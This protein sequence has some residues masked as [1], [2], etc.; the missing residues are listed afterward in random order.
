MEPITKLPL[1][2]ILT[3]SQL[4]RKIKDLLE[5]NFPEVWVEG[6][7]S[8][9][10]IPGS[11]HLYFTLKDD[12]CQ[13]RAV[14]FRMQARSLRYLPEDGLQVVCRG[15][16]GLYEKRGDYQLI[17]DSM[18]PK[19][20]GAL[21]LAFLQ[22]KD[23][24]E[25]EGLFA[26]ER[27]KAVP[28]VPGKIGIVTSPTG[29]A[30]RDM[31]H[32]IHRRFE[33]VR[34]LLYPARV[35]GNGAWREIVEGI[36]FFNQERNVDVILIGRGGG[37]LEDLWAFNEEGLARAI[38]RSKIPIVS[39]VGHET[40]YTIS[41]FVADLR[42]PTPS[43]AAEQVVRDKKEVLN[44]LRSL[45]G[46]M[47]GE[48]A[49]TFQLFRS[50]LLHLQ[51][52][53]GSPQKALG[54]LMLRVDDLVERLERRS[55]LALEQR[56]ER[57]R[58]LIRRLQQT[59]PSG[60]IMTTR[61]LISET[62]KHLDHLIGHGIEIKEQKIRGVIGKLNALSPLSILERGYSIVRKLPA[63][64][65]LR[66]SRQVDPGDEVEIRLHRGVIL[67]EVKKTGLTE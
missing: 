15:Q 13:I 9:L 30:I 5:G 8:N 2:S 61:F 64:D 3:V 21:Q 59:S 57:N 31:L 33:N 19:G 1:R 17:L 35:Q 18:E 22:L 11:G 56:R 36:E 12:F 47:E 53:L 27:K 55:I 52:I 6:E 24:L 10:R 45:K 34:I 54:T 26:P 62:R 60:K 50:R 40:D 48:M 67:C 58:N 41:D 32:V 43:A 16:V 14:M 66:E 65:V 46:R 23:K 63:L 37:S 38:A 4:T 49:H 39:A 25:K 42:A 51:K 28:M 44:T 29:A 7:V 20:I